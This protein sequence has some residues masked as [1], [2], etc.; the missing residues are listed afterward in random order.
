MWEKLQKYLKE[1]A[2][3]LRKMT[4]PTKDELIGSTVVVIVTSL[5]IAVFIGIVDWALSSLVKMIFTSA[6]QGG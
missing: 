2:G 1:T 4:W 5:I 3:E 6:G